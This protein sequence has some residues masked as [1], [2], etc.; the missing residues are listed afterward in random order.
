[1]RICVSWCRKQA[2]VEGLERNKGRNYMVECS[3]PKVRNEPRIC[4]NSYLGSSQSG[5]LHHV[6]HEQYLGTPIVNLE[7][8]LHLHWCTNMTG[9]GNNYNALD[10]RTSEA[11]RN[12]NI[13]RSQGAQVCGMDT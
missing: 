2:E 6:I 11:C 4:S 10:P 13:Q 5:A 9:N 12:Y 1:M 8:G 3:R 7:L